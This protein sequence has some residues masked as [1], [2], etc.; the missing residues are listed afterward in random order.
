MPNE[1]DAKGLFSLEARKKH[2]IILKFII[3][4]IHYC[5]KLSEIVTNSI[6]VL[7]IS[8]QGCLIIRER[9]KKFFKKGWYYLCIVTNEC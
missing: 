9:E 4:T 6:Y 7:I 5:L 2:P 1:V 3:K 8:I